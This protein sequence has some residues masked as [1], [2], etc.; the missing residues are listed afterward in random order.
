MQKR[1][2]S[3]TLTAALLILAALTGCN[4]DNGT[5]GTPYTYPPPVI[6]PY[7]F[8]LMTDTTID[9][10]NGNQ[11]TLQTGSIRNP[12]YIP[13]P[14]DYHDSRPNSLYDEPEFLT[15]FTLTAKDSL[16]TFW[17]QITLP[18]PFAGTYI[19]DGRGHTYSYPVLPGYYTGSSNYK[20]STGLYLVVLT[21]SFSRMDELGIS[22]DYYGWMTNITTQ[23]KKY[24]YGSFYK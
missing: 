23:N 21:V 7:A 20:D 17:L 9:T 4:K 24:I 2:H 11:V 16:K 22:G 6:P 13:P 19:L 10:L 3:F 5:Q 12:N 14:T 18:H 8:T 1:I 15:S